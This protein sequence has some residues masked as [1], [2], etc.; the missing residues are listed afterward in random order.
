MNAMQGTL[1]IAGDIFFR[2][3]TYL[4][5]IDVLLSWVPDLKQSKLGY[6]VGKMTDPLLD[7]FRRFLV[8]GVMDFSP[9]AVI[10]II[11]IVVQ[12]LYVLIIT[13]IF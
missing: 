4:V 9:I 13:S 12:P 1:L 7:P 5:I 8:I 6:W 11:R 3:V 2:L 10:A